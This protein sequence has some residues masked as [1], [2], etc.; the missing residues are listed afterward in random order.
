MLINNDKYRMS[1]AVWLAHNDYVGS[2]NP[3]AISATT[4]I[5]PLKE[6]VLQ[7]QATAAGETIAQTLDLDKMIPSRMGHSI[8]DSIQKVWTGDEGNISTILKQL[9][10]PEDTI[11]RIVV[12]PDNES[13][14][15]SMIPIFVEQRFGRTIKSLH[16][17]VH[18]ITGQVD[19]ICDGIL[20]D[21]KSTSVYNWIF[22]SNKDKYIQQA[23]IYRWLAP[24]LIKEDYFYIHYILLPTET[25]EDFYVKYSLK[26]FPLQSGYCR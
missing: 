22:Q 1:L 21:F 4:L 16:N 17:N 8:H 19:F 23:S 20:E 5:K 6:I 25:L 3:N 12:N 18:A 7:R 10:Y 2:K 11:D 9:G 13:A 26:K 24:Y 15:S 14:N